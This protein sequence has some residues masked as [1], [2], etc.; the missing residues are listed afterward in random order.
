MVSLVEKEDTYI[1]T[2]IY[3]VAN[4]TIQQWPE[5]RSN[6]FNTPI[7]KYSGLGLGGSDGKIV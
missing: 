7:A 4:S 1:H 2:I 3:M 5:F 6:S